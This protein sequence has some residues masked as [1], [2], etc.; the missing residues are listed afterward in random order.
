MPTN[1]GSNPPVISFSTP[2]EPE[3]S[4]KATDT[5]NRPRSASTP[6]P[7]QS[8]FEGLKK[9]PKN[10]PKDENSSTQ[11][12]AFATYNVPQGPK[13]T[14]RESGN[15][16]TD[17]IAEIAQILSAKL[18]GGAKLGLTVPVPGT[19][20]YSA[21]PSKPSSLRAT[22]VLSTAGTPQVSPQ[23][24]RSISPNPIPD[25]KDKEQK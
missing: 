15:I 13:G 16:T 24:S 3:Q 4:T 20:S 8:S 25:E 21:E 11:R 2:T 22:P 12:D 5:G 18:Q 14:P 6:E 7:S 17:Q 1:I 23:P 19:P 9:R 10:V